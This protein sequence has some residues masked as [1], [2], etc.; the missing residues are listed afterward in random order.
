[1]ARRLDC[2]ACELGRRRSRQQGSALDAVLCGLVATQERP[3]T[4]VAT[5]KAKPAGRRKIYIVELRFSGA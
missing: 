1:M 5:R 4:R 2:V 3:S